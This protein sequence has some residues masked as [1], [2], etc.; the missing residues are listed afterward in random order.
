MNRVLIVHCQTLFSSLV[1]DCEP[2]HTCVCVCVCARV[3]VS[4]G[5]NN[6]KQK[7]HQTTC[8][9]NTLTGF[10]RSIFFTFSFHV[11]VELHK[12]VKRGQSGRGLVGL[13]EALFCCCLPLFLPV[14]ACWSSSP[15]YSLGLAKGPC[16]D[17]RRRDIVI[18][19]TSNKKHQ[20]NK[21]S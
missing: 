3:C 10:V 16:V 15:F 11:Q 2:V 19:H 20:T 21:Q 9:Y 1:R 12:G 8:I 7:Q 4:F 5:R 14:L 17:R 18:K 6:T 13:F